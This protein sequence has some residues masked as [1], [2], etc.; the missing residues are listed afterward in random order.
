MCIAEIKEVNET[1]YTQHPTSGVS[2]GKPQ[3]MSVAMVTPGTLYG[4][5]GACEF[6]AHDFGGP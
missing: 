1:L 2:V 4:G 5:E 6:S 3:M